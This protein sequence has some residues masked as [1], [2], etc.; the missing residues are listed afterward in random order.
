[1]HVHSASIDLFCRK[2]WNTN[3]FLQK[4]IWSKKNQVQMHQKIILRILSSSA[5]RLEI[6]RFVWIIFYRFNLRLD[7]SDETKDVWTGN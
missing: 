2:S 6:Y 3:S 4:S 5:L 1:M 7:F